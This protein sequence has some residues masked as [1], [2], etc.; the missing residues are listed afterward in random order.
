QLPGPSNEFDVVLKTLAIVL[1]RNLGGVR[2]RF[3]DSAVLLDDLPG[4]LFA[5][6]RSAGDVVD[7]VPPEAEELDDLI[8]AD[9]HFFF[10]D[11]RVNQPHLS[12]SFGTEDFYVIVY[13]LAE[14]FVIGDDQ[15]VQS[16]LLSLTSEGADYVVGLILWMASDRHSQGFKG[17]LDVGELKRQIVGHRLWGCFVLF[18]SFGSERGFG[19]IQRTAEIIWFFGSDQLPKHHNEPVD[20]ICRQPLGVRKRGQRVIGTIYLRHPIDQE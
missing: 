13:E 10:Y 20:R 8:R 6:A 2:Y 19:R 14:V 15:D 16:G 1:S 4:S 11:L 12:G 18:V 9:A 7:G 5:D 17:P 3:L